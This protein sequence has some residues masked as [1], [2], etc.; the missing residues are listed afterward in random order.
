PMALKINNATCKCQGVGAFWDMFFVMDQFGRVRPGPESLRLKRKR[1]GIVDVGSKTIDAYISEGMEPVLGSE[2][3]FD[4]GIRRAY[5]LV[6]DQLNNCPEQRIEKYYLDWLNTKEELRENLDD[7]FWDGVYYS[8]TEIVKLCR[9]AFAEV[10]TTVAQRMKE[11]WNA[12]LAVLELI[13]I[14]GGGALSM[15]FVEAFKKEFKN[16]IEVAS[17]P[18]FANCKGYVKSHKYHRIAQSLLKRM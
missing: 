1:F 13:V 11:L 15:D 4:Y 12:E 8:A 17:D 18:Q 10:G 6:S 5:Q 3:V 9:Q 2:E 14:C 16:R 7:L